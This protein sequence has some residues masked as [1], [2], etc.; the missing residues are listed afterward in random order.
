MTAVTSVM[1]HLAEALGC[2]STGFYRQAF[3]GVETSHPRGGPKTLRII[4]AEK[5]SAARTQLIAAAAQP[6]PRP[7]PAPSGSGCPWPR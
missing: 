7:A 2:V 5:C 6:P 3:P 1:G 4:T